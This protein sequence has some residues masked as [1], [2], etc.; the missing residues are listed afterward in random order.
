MDKHI[1]VEENAQKFWEW[2]KT[3]GGLAIWESINLSNP[4]KSWTTPFANEKGEPYR[5]P[6]WEAE[7]TPSRII[8]DPSDVVVSLPREWKRFHI[9]IRRGDQGF[10]MKVTD[11][12]TR[13]IRTAVEKAY[14][15]TKK[16][17]WYQFDYETQE[18]VIMI[19]DKL[20]PLPEYVKKKGWE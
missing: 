15:I 7:N 18:A 3:R 14:E 19:D 9:S 10:I 20:I 16:T 1:V 12:S 17:S 2:L 6:T 11:A 4:G 5:K 8:T 13:R